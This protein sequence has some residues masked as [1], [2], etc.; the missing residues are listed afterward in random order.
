MLGICARFNCNGIVLQ[1]NA[2]NETELTTMRLSSLVGAKSDKF[3]TRAKHNEWGALEK[4]N[5]SMRTSMAQKPC[6]RKKRNVTW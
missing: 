1:A 4:Q 5:K 2:W 6:E 3:I